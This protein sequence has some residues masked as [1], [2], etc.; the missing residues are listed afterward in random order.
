MLV[1][2]EEIFG[3]LLSLKT[4]EAGIGDGIRDIARIHLLPTTLAMTRSVNAK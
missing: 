3:P 1:M 4:Y 2:Q